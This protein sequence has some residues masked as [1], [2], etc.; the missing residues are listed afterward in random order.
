MENG[1]EEGMWDDEGNLGK[2]DEIE[3]ESECIVGVGKY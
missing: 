3:E 1:L 2:K